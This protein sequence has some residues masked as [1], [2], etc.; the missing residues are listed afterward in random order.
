M[1][2]A[3]T[4]IANADSRAELAAS[5]A[6]LVA[7][8]DQARERI[9]RNLHDGAM[10]HFLAVA[11]QFSAVQDS[12]PPELGQ[13]K[14]KLSQGPVRSEQCRGRPAGDLP[15]H[16]SDDACCR[17]ADSR[18]EGACP[19]LLVLQRRVD[20]PMFTNAD[21]AVL[22]GLLHRLPVKQL[23]QLLLLVRPD[24]ILRWHRD[25]LKRRHAAT[26]APRRRG[27]PPTVRSIRTL[28]LRLASFW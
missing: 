15:G 21:R 6:R 5:R 16:L 14:A 2:L 19:Q 20:K 26:C 12:L 25:L 1:S 8:A 18:F 7:A 11:M 13:A 27:R 23:Q 17:R 9:E 10:Q 22:A 24:T 4:A 3:A 28:V